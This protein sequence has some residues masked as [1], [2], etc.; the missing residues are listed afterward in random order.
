ME[1]REKDM[2][3]D[4]LR[5]RRA[6]IGLLERL[7]RATEELDRGIVTRKEKHKEDEAEIT[8]ELQ[9]CRGKGMVDRAALKQLTGVLKDLQ[10]ILCQD[11]SMDTRERELKLMQLERNLNA[12][13]DSGV[14]V[15]LAGEAERYAE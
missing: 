11:C 14:V 15:T 1:E 7:E 5:I 13:S 2:E 8:F 9:K 12:G 3:E 4:S 6:A 10:D